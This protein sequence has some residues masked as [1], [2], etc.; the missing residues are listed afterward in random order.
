MVYLPTCQV[1]E[2]EE[3]LAAARREVTKTEEANQKLQRDVKEVSINTVWCP[4]SP[5]I[6]GHDCYKLP[7]A[8]ST[9]ATITYNQ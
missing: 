3:Q 9:K 5:F 2:I 6:N 8:S 1:G 7:T 4:Y